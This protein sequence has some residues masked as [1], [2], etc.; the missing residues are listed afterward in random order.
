MDPAG[1]AIGLTDL[2]GLF[3]SCTDC[4]NFLPSNINTV[5]GARWVSLCN[6]LLSYNKKLRSSSLLSLQVRQM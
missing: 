5:L 3:T 2:A 1:F 4:F 6:T